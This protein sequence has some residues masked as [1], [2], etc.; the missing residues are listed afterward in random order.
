MPRGDGTGPQGKG[1][2]TGGGR[3]FGRGEA[4]G[5]G[6]GRGPGIGRGMFSVTGAGIPG[7]SVR[8]YQ[9]AA[10]ELQEL[11][12]LKARARQVDQELKTLQ[13]RIS[14]LEGKK[15]VSHRILVDKELCMGC[16]RCEDACTRDAIIVREIAE[17]DQSLCTLCGRCV[18]ECPVDALRLE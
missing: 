14:G 13:K 5:M 4:R 10:G 3:S 18:R 7:D 8:Q 15:A 16:G 2:M 11:D 12:Q 9:P 1:L 17:V 6:Q